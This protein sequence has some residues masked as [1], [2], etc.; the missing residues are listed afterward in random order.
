MNDQHIVLHDDVCH[1]CGGLIW[2]VRHPEGRWEIFH[3]QCRY[4][5]T[6][7]I[8]HLPK[9]LGIVTALDMHAGE[10]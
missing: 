10:E 2:W 5:R 1:D 8:C 9:Y 7:M 6:D 3:P 4:G